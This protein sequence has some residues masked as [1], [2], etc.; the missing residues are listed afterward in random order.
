[1]HPYLC[2]RM[3]W[4]KEQI[5]NWHILFLHIFFSPS[6]SLATLFISLPFGPGCL[7]LS[8]S[9]LFFPRITLS[10]AGGI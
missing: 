2:I 3:R 10:V 4:Y 5:P 8:L 1:M 9:R 7:N 6:L